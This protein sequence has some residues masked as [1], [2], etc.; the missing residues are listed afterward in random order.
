MTNKTP[1]HLLARHKP[2][3]P[4]SSHGQ[5]RTALVPWW[6][7]GLFALILLPLLVGFVGFDAV[8]PSLSSASTP[9]RPVTSDSIQ[10]VGQPAGTWTKRI[11]DSEFNGSSLDGSRWTTG[12]G[13]SGITED[14]NGDAQ[15]C[16]DP[17]QVGMGQGHLNLTVISQTEF[18]NGTSQPYTSGAVTTDGAFSFTYGYM[19]ARLWM[20]G[21]GSV[22]DWPAF[23]ADGQNWPKTGEIDTVEGLDGAA[24]YHFIDLVG[25][26][27]S[28]N[29]ACA[30]GSFS[31]GWHTFAADWEPGSVTYYYDGTEMWQDTTG[32]TAKPMYLVLDLAVP[33]STIAPDASPVAPARMKVDYVRVWQH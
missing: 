19:E 21:S 9:P 20:P 15:D 10:P 4:G 2:S 8:Q 30:S 18:C 6:R 23:W 24:C 11:F 1:W 5:R 33:D 25:T 3:T 32:I 22:S 17:K 12:W 29:G 16:Y 27:P 31:G 7:R 14:P 13:G 26:L 28:S